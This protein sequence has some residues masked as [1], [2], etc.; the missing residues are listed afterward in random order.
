MVSRI[1]ELINCY[2]AQMIRMS[3]EYCKGNITKLWNDFKTIGNWQQ[4]SPNLLIKTYSL[5]PLEIQNK[6]A[7]ILR[8]KL[9]IRK[10]SGFTFYRSFIKKTLADAI[11]T[12]NWPFIFMMLECGVPINSR[13]IN[14]STLLHEAVKIA[15]IEI[16]SD[17]LKLGLDPNIR[18]QF[19]GTPLHYAVTQ[20]QSEKIIQK[21]IQ[22]G[23]NPNIKDKN[24]SIP[25]DIV[26]Q[27]KYLTAA[28]TLIK[29][30]S[31]IN[32]TNTMRQTALHLACE[33]NEEIALSL[34]KMEAD[35]NSKDLYGNTP[36]HNAC[37][38]NMHLLSK[39]L[40]KKNAAIFVFNT[41]D[42]TPLC[43]ADST[44]LELFQNNTTKRIWDSIK[45][46]NSLKN[47]NE[48]TAEKIIKKWIDNNHGWNL[49][50]L[51]IERE[52][53]SEYMI[54]HHRKYLETSLKT[55]PFASLDFSQKLSL[56]PLLPPEEIASTL[57]QWDVQE[58][59]DRLDELVIWENYLNKS[60]FDALHQLYYESIIQID[61]NDNEISSP[62]TGLITEVA[63][64]FRDLPM[65]TFSAACSEESTF[66][67]IMKCVSVLSPDQLAIFTPTLSKEEF[68]DVAKKLS[69]ENQSNLIKCATDE[70]KRAYL[71]EIG[72]RHSTVLTKWLYKQ[73]FQLYKELDSIVELS[74]QKGMDVESK[75]QAF[76]QKLN[77]VAGKL[78]LAA[79]RNTK[80]LTLLRN[81]FLLNA[82][83]K[84]L[85]HEVNALTARLIQES[86]KAVIQ[87]N[88][89]KES[90]FK[91]SRIKF[92][93]P[94]TD[95]VPD[96][97]LCGIM[98]T[99]MKDPVK[100][101]GHT[102]DRENI[103]KWLE[104]HST[105]PLCRCHVSIDDF[106][107]DHQLKETI[108]QYN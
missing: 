30:G 104:N 84:D 17:L 91:Q 20:P 81:A 80:R 1:S 61:W 103:E 62:S 58:I 95:E 2:P 69:N 46:V 35:I 88:T 105:C 39:K 10:I 13:V 8:V 23:A 52:S 60:A 5:L 54:T 6:T 38:A 14:K 101:H 68:I 70:Q 78:P 40:I 21:L 7:S 96:E 67:I 15:N 42:K 65:L 100:A 92:S 55:I 29:L 34:M 56:L 33:T 50:N 45:V 48:Q 108:E 85:K 86:K 25:L 11:Y 82:P 64:F 63:S 24:K 4:H 31:P 9:A 43:Y 102:F 16:V 75:A 27:R 76:T 19:G 49:F 89:L 94:T 83:S 59:E 106:Q 47:G 98:Q 53:V 37:K 12:K 99:P 44:L 36:L 22:S 18:D 3:S 72:I 57:D 97:F 90:I 32:R 51:I 73:K 66:E 93:T 79:Q 28:H 74:Y 77:D 107:S 87:L 41:E 26:L 71:K